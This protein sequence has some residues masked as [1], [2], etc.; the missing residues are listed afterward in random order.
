MN[1]YHDRIT[2]EATATMTV[3]I[4]LIE[5]TTKSN[6]SISLCSILPFAMTLIVNINQ[7][8]ELEISNLKTRVDLTELKL[9]DSRIETSNLK[10]WADLT[11]LR[12]FD[13]M[14]QLEQNKMEKEA[15]KKEQFKVERARITAFGANLLGK[16]LDK[17]DK[18]GKH[19]GKKTDMTQ[20]NSSAPDHSSNRYQRAA[21]N[22]NESKF[23]ATGLP[24]KCFRLLK[25][26]PEVS[27]SVEFQ[28]RSRCNSNVSLQ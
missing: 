11:E 28:V 16:F 12:I 24:N 20:N 4:P 23:K 7:V 2:A 18:T 13:L 5:I 27:I 26:Y 1:A 10:T 17:V 25:L 3:V 15:M 14:T 21:E 22:F 9:F 19:S 6:N 8:L